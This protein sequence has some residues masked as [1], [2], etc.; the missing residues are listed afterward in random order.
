VFQRDGGR[1]VDCRT[2]FDLQ[3]HRLIPLALDGSNDVENLQRLCG[4]CNRRKGS[5]LG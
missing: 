5:T 4:D 2:N 3:Y 1:C